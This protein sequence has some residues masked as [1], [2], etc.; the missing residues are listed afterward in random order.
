MDDFREH[1]CADS[2]L[3]RPRLDFCMFKTEESD[4]LQEIDFIYAD[5]RNVVPAEVKSMI[6]ILINPS[7]D[8]SGNTELS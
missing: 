8:S 2:D 5:G 4:R 1:D 3:H 7:T 6:S